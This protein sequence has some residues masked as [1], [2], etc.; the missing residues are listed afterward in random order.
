MITEMVASD[1]EG[2]EGGGRSS[3]RDRRAGGGSAS[4]KARPGSHGS[5]SA[6]DRGTL[7][8]SSTACAFIWEVNMSAQLDFIS[9]ALKHQ[10]VSFHSA[11]FQSD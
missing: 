2:T 10:A 5:K 4:G 7:A 11:C 1:P 9:P 3:D 8:E 6:K